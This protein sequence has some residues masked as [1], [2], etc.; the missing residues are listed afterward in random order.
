MGHASLQEAV[1]DLE[2]SRD[3]VRID[4]EV[5]PKLEAG[6]IQRRVLE[7]G[8]PALLF[9]RVRGTRFPMLANLFGSKKRAEFLFRDA[10][11][12]V[13]ALVSAR[14]DP[15]ALV[16]SPMSALRLPGAALHLLPRKVRSGPVMAGSCRVSELPQLVSWPDDG[17]PFV[18]LPQVYTEDPDEPGIRRSNLGMYRIQLAGNQYVPDREI[19]LHYQL[20]RGIGVHHSKAEAR[21]AKLPVAIF[22]GGPPAM[23]VAAVMPL[24]EGMPE[25]H[26][27]GALGGRAVRIIPGWDGLPSVHADADFC[28]LGFVHPGE[29]KPEGPFGDHLGYYSKQHD[30]PVLHVTAVHHR[31]DAI[32][33]FTTVGRPP[34]EDTIFGELIHELTAPLVP[35]VLPGVEAVH[36]V[37]ASGVHPLLLA[38]GSERYTPFAKS[39]QPMELLTQASAIL[40]NG[41]MSLAKYLFIA[42]RGGKPPS[43]HDVGEF[44]QHVLARIDPGRDLHFHVNTTI[45]TLDYSGSGLNLGS[46]LVV[47]ACGPARRALGR[48][49]PA[50]GLPVGYKDLRVVIPGILALGGPRFDRPEEIDALGEALVPHAPAL[51]GFPLVVVCDDPDFVARSLANFLWVTFTRSNPAVDVHGVGAFVRHKAWGCRGP[52]LIDARAKPHHAAPLEMDPAVTARVDALFAQGGPLAGLG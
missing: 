18:T 28:I 35:E 37:D 41:Q 40:G 39:A 50:V 22:V 23:T 27:A 47:A 30:F 8:G 32:W 36:A 15:S 24:P 20:H 5:D 10:L 11:A 1:R 44:F 33:P 6:V 14:V 25:L 48:T 34:Q 52:V 43:I 12:G 42:D 26:F 16:R 38:I 49:V 51:D 3:L 2:R 29:T 45:D 9:E 19:G 13:R 7:A 17:G 21:G 31:A 46:K 4:V